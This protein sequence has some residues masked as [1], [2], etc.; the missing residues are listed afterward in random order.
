ML[1]GNFL[2]QPSHLLEKFVEMDT[3]VSVTSNSA[4]SP[5]W[6]LQILEI[7]ATKGQGS[8]FTPQE[9]C[10]GIR[11]CTR[12]LWPPCLG[13]NLSPAIAACCYQV[14]FNRGLLPEEREQAPSHLKPPLLFAHT[15][16]SWCINGRLLLLLLALP[17]SLRLLSQGLGTPSSFLLTLGTS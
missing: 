15:P 17:T 13:Y 3:L 2:F 16:C 9:A 8:N 5:Y 4:L 11:I 1:P 14:S 6:G 7:P 12:R 10:S